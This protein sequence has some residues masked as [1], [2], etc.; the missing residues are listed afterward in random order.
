[1]DVLAYHL[2][3]LNRQ[4]CTFWFWFHFARCVVYRSAHIYHF[5][6]FRLWQIKHPWRSPY[7]SGARCQAPKLHIARL[8]PAISRQIISY[9]AVY[10]ITFRCLIKLSDCCN[11]KTVSRS[12]CF[13]EIDWSHSLC[14]NSHLFH[15]VWCVTWSQYVCRTV[16]LTVVCVTSWP[17]LI[18]HI[19]SR[20]GL[21]HPEQ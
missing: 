18:H 4:A 3:C 19:P 13:Y 20:Q 12:V 11:M 16:S 6:F 1:V 7:R 15:A 10:T 5:L 8:F 9:N 2:A 17:S 21:S 14:S